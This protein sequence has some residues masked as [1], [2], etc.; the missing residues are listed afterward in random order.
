MVCLVVE[1]SSEVRESVCLLL[2]ELG[3]LGVPAADRPGAEA[4]LSSRADI[5]T[6]IVDVDNR[7]VDAARLLAGLRRRG[8]RSLAHSVKREPEPAV[9]PLVDGVLLKPFDE[10]R[11]VAALKGL[12]GQPA[13]VA[14]EKRQHMR[15]SP[16]P[17]ELLR[18]SFRITASSR[19]YTGRIRNISVGGA[20]IEIYK[21]PP[22]AAIQAGW[23]IPRL[24]FILG[25]APLAPAAVV[26]LYRRRLIAVRFESMGRGERAALARYVYDKLTAT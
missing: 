20:A 12:L 21:A 26:I 22:D 15:V 19:L 13:F 23:R 17:S 3:I 5:T 2:L 7:D 4:L 1:H 16:E 11:T 9:R 8:I 10:A 25:A 14:A 24:E 18:A 6:A